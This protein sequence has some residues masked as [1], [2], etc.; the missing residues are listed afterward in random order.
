MRAMAEFLRDYPAGKT[1]GRYVD[2]SVP[3][4][5]FADGAFDLA[6]SSHFLF[7]YTTQ[8]GEIFH[9]LAVREMCRVAR[10][11]RIFPLLALGGQSSPLVGVV[12]DDMRS[13]G[14]LVSLERVAYEFQ[15]GGDQMMRIAAP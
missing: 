15:R 14:R 9:R 13:Q 4:L 1:E 7:L 8:L 5:P 3:S 10:A 12:V 11:V 2:A 6:L